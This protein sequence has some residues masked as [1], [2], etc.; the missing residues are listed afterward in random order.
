MN[1]NAIGALAELLGAVGV[2][3]SLIYLAGQ[4]R[5]GAKQARQAAVQ[6]AMDKVHTV[7]ANMAVYRETADLWVR[8]RRGQEFLVDEEEAV[9]FSGFVFSIMR[10]YE[11]IFHYHQNG[12][13]DDWAWHS[14]NGFCRA[15]MG[16]PGFADWWKLRGPW[17]SSEFERFVDGTLET[18]PSYE[19]FKAS[20]ESDAP[21]AG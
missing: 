9:R 18:L 20:T 19:P 13:V 1:W 11:E 7:F 14:I 6:S 3:A 15:V 17:F 8:G 12:A 21:P 16:T 2:I 10:P 4:V 5:G